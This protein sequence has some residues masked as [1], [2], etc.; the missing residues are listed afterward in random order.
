MAKQTLPF[1]VKDPIQNEISWIIQQHEDTNHYY[2]DYLPYE[3]HLRMV[4]QAGK[5]F[6]WLIDVLAEYYIRTGVI[7]DKSYFKSNIKKGLWG[8]D[9][10]EDTR[11]NYNDVKKNLG[12]FTA[13]IVRACT[14]YGRGRDRNERMPDFVYEDIRNTPGALFVKLCDRIAN[15]QYSKMT[16]SSMFQKYKKENP[17]FFEMLGYTEDHVLKPMFDYIQKLFDNE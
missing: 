8:H 9:L 16:R 10:I 11:V 1:K 14:N 13:E 6:E 3:F 5:D 2:D 17:H 7:A 15:V 12:E 4:A